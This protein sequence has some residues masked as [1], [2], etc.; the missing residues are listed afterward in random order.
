M[1]K[2]F[3]FALAL[4]AALSFGVQSAQALPATTSWTDGGLNEMIRFTGPLTTSI[5]GKGFLTQTSTMSV[6]KPTGGTVIAAYLTTVSNQSANAPTDV[7]LNNQNVT[8]SHT[9]KT[10][11][12]WN[13]ANFFAD[14][15][16]LVKPTL[17]AA[18]AGSVSIA[19][20]EGTEL[21]TSAIDGQELVVIFNDPAKVNNPSSVVIAFG[22]ARQSGDSFTLNFP[23]LTNLGTQTA[24]L[25]L[26][27]AFSWQSAGN[28]SQQSNIKVSTS[29]QSTLQWV[30]QTAGG[31]NDGTNSDGALI[32]VGDSGDSTA[33]PELTETAEDDELYGLGS[34]LA[35]GDT[36]ITI[37]TENS[38]LND[39]VFQAVL[40]LD[41]VQ[42]DGAE[43]VGDPVE[44]SENNEG[45]ANTGNGFPAWPLTLGLA[46]TAAGSAIVAVRRRC[47]SS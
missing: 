17:D 13:F 30:S 45:L 19:I 34:F 29:S 23:A 44:S 37:N 10:T 11:T 31:Q 21:G 27:I 14:V 32:T 39:N 2:K 1:K 24:T 38:S 42:V 18:S 26:G 16:S 6:V 35:V 22:A 41:G 5:S 36:S 47:Q 43:S 7:K 8:Y 25:S 15:T 9:A 46:A 4:L 40:I 12:G 20:D 33:L 28:K 3:T